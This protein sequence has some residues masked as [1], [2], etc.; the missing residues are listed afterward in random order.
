MAVL[1]DST[2]IVDVVV[3]AEGRKRLLADRDFK[4]TKFSLE[5]TEIDYSLWNPSH[6]SGI[7]S[8]G[9]VIENSSVL[10][11][12]ANNEYSYGSTEYRTIN[13]YTKE[14]VIEAEIDYENFLGSELV[15]LGN[16][17]YSDVTSHQQLKNLDTKLS[18]DEFKRYTNEVNAQKVLSETNAS[19]NNVI[20]NN[21]KADEN[22]SY[23]NSLYEYT[24]RIYDYLTSTNEDINEQIIEFK[25]YF[26]KS[27]SVLDIPKS[28]YG[29]KVTPG[30]FQLTD[31]S[32][33][34]L[35]ITV[36][37]DKKGNLF[38]ITSGSIVTT[39]LI[40]WFPFTDTVIYETGSYSGYIYG[41]NKKLQLRFFTSSFDTGKVYNALSFNGSSSYATLDH[42]NLITPSASSD[43]AVSLLINSNETQQGGYS[44]Y[45][46]LDNGDVDTNAPYRIKLNS[47]LQ[48]L[49]QRSSQGMIISECTGS[50]IV[51]GSFHHVI[52]QKDGA[53]LKLFVN[54]T[55]E[56]HSAVDTS[57]PVYNS[58]DLLV[59][60]GSN[61]SKWTGMIDQLRFY[62]RALTNQE[63]TDLNNVPF[64]TNKVGNIFYNDGIAVFTYM[65]G[66][67]KKFLT[68][69]SG[70]GY[71]IAFRSTVTLQEYEVVAIKQTNELNFTNN[72]TV[73][74]E[75][76]DGVRSTVTGSGFSPYTTGINFF[77]DDGV[78]LATGKFKNPIKVNQSFPLIFTM[79]FDKHR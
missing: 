35:T 52:V 29:E 18:V 37:D 61:G 62:N 54:G 6:P 57:F 77:D 74:N 45:T 59:A 7:D 31:K 73:L 32:E 25:N 26:Y 36:R 64:N 43:F 50:T 65:S 23:S 47:D 71:D 14:S 9:N 79:R 78:R 27:A 46:I 12:N 24:R 76:H 30:T 4:I 34:G 13:K 38:D 75:S 69:D 8:Y 10:E 41:D 20:Y 40:D 22:Y 21:N 72:E 44:E 11:P 51:T 67:Y 49:I 1:S 66:S 55:E 17:Q 70:N 5:D 33:T 56:S 63:I 3:T 60:T 39:G 28:T 16:S 58:R 15:T 53:N 48:P 19:V 2:I 42:H 68:D